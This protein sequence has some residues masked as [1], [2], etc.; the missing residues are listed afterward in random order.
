M[1]LKYREVSLAALLDR[2][3]RRP[4]A[5]RKGSLSGTTR[6]WGSLQHLRTD[7]DVHIRGCDFGGLSNIETDA[8]LFTRDTIVT[9]LPANIRHKGTVLASVDTVTNR[10][11]MHYSGTFQEVD[12]SSIIVPLLSEDFSKNHQIK[13]FISGRFTSI[14][15][16]SGARV[17][18]HSTS[19][20]FDR[21]Q[22]DSILAQCDITA[23]GIAV[24]SFSGRDS[25]RSHVRGEGFI[26]WS[27]FSNEQQKEDSIRAQMHIEGDLLA[28]FERNVCVPNAIPI[29]GQGTGSIDIGIQG[30]AGNIRVSNAVI[31]IPQGILR[32]TTL[33][34]G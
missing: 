2:L 29:T 27:V 7:S 1:T 26:P 31:Q 30:S 3:A 11:G 19:F 20:V 16:T 24:T 28:S 15:S 10:N 25:L 12:L 8:L 33:C 17:D 21:W 32:L 23:G 18:L 4:G 34:S 9:I 22:L 13:C 5:L 6:L 14:P